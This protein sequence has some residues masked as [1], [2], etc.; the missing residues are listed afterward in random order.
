MTRAN[1]DGNSRTSVHILLQGKGGVGKSFIA[2]ILTQYFLS[3]GAER[4][5]HRCGSLEPNPGGILWSVGEP[6]ES[7]ERGKRGPA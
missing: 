7:L 2:S 3:K 4:K 1:G 6:T 5:C